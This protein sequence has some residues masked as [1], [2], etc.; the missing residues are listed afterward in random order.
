MSDELYHC[1]RCEEDWTVE[2]LVHSNCPKC[3]QHVVV[4]LRPTE[5]FDKGES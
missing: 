2:Q 4:V 5:D 1:E 3:N